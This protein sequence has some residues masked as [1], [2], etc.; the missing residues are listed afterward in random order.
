MTS[1]RE[2]SN[3]RQPALIYCRVSSTKQ[4]TEGHGLD[5]Q[6]LRCRQYAEQRGYEVE[7]VFPDD[8]SGGGDFMKRPGMV[9][10]LSY[11]DAK[12]HENFVIVFDDLKRFARD[13]DF[14]FSLRRALTARGAKPECLNFNFDDSPEGEFVET[15]FAAQG[16]LEREQ[17]RRQVIQKMTACVD[18]GRYVFAPPI[19]Y[20]YADVNGTSMLV[21][22]EPNAT[23]VRECLEKFAAGAYQSPVEIQRYMTAQPSTPKLKTGKVNINLVTGMLRR[24]LYAG[25]IRIEKWGGRLQQGTHEALISVETWKRIQDRLERGSNAPAR[26]DIKES[27]P[28]RNFVQC[29][30]CGSAM[31]AGFS[32]GR[33]A[34]YPYY[35]CQQKGCSQHR[36]SIRGE[37]IEGEFTELLRSLT[38]SPKLYALGHAMLKKAWNMRIEAASS[39][40]SRAQADLARLEK[41]TDQMMD[42]IVETDSPTLITAY[43][44]KIRKMEEEKAVL[45]EQAARKQNEP[46]HEFETIYRT[47]LGFIANPL[48]VWESGPLPIKRMVLRMTFGGKLAYCRE[49]GYRTADIALPFRLFGA[50]SAPRVEMVEPRG[51]EPLTSSLRTTRSPN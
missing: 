33:S 45:R 35:F 6:E 8:V 12:P 51:I 18:H 43:E 10:L 17:N 20:K 1:T 31:T 23:I 11:L 25:L 16:Q 7:A 27:F 44:A 24:P 14:H 30:E 34:T 40:R 41:M 49:T 29:S 26:K 4:K 22:D 28:L 36:K 19:G 3:N 5:S 13:R 15:I 9:A 21:P 2:I 32:R 46:L 38:P 42:R 47:A 50:R 48:Q 37:K 39:R